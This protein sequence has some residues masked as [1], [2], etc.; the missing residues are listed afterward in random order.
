MQTG[1]P[2]DIN[3]D[4]GPMSNSVCWGFTVIGA[5]FVGVRLY[6]RGALH[7]KLWVDDYWIILSLI[8]TVLT[9]ILTSLAVSYGGGKH[10]QAFDPQRPE[11]IRGA[12]LWLTTANVPSIMSIALP[13]MAVISL[14]IRL[15]VPGPRH[16]MF[17]LVMGTICMLSLSACA[18]QLMLQ[19]SPPSFLWNRQGPEDQSGTCLSL[20]T[21]EYLS[22]WC[23]AYSAFLDFY[24]ALY[25]SYKLFNL[26]MPLQKKIA[27]SVALGFGVVYVFQSK[28]MCPSWYIS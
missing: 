21:T 28:F 18:M 1:P 6:V 25:P 7:K 19:C 14:L 13:K 9:S 24:L 26:Q 16:R 4:S 23:G 27:L 15:L 5:I 20:K 10:M 8:C 3:E 2:F 22:Y 11:R 12:I 17:L